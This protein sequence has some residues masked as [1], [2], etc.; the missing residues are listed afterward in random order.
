MSKQFRNKSP[1]RT[2][3]KKKSR[4]NA[5]KEELAK[6]FNHRCGYTDCQ[7]RW[8]LGSRNF[9]IDHLKPKSK[10]PALENEYSNLVYC[11]SY[12]NLAKGDDDS[13]M[14]LDPCDI[15]YNEHFER[16]DDGTIVPKTPEAHYMYS[17]LKLYLKRYSVIWILEQIS[18]RIDKLR[19]YQKTGEHKDLLTELLNELQGEF[20]T[21]AQ[22]L[23][24]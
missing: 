24:S 13:L 22:Y 12:V 3:T 11:C 9:H 19:Q 7:D 10:Y 14:Y 8:L 16:D 18:Q 15:D 4:Y 5:Y 17:H 1:K 2:C 21:Y 23:Y 6:D 20:Y